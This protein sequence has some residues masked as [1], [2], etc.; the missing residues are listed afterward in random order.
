MTRRVPSDR[1]YIEARID[2]NDPGGCWLW[3]G[4]VNQEGYGLVCR[5]RGASPQRAHR[6]V[7]AVLVGPV[8]TGTEMDH[9]CHVRHCVNPEHLQAVTHAVNI[10]PERAPSWI[11]NINRDKTHCDYGHEFSD[12]NTSLVSIVRN[13]NH[14]TL[15]HCRTCQRRRAAERAKRLRVARQELR[16]RGVTVKVSFDPHDDVYIAVADHRA[17]GCASRGESIAEALE[18]FADAY[19]ARLSLPEAMPA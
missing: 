7:F 14:Y 2:R 16:S 19:R 12:E 8:P 18:N 17:A 6:F 15:R 1:E 3:T 13:G 10:S 5:R 11:A 9:L 4:H